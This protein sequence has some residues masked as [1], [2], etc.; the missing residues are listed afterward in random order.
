[1]F[2]CVRSGCFLTDCRAQLTQPDAFK[3][4]VGLVLISLLA[5]QIVLLFVLRTFV[6]HR[7]ASG[8]GAGV[9]AVRGGGA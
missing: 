5:V 9:G 3:L 2:A 7:Q 6:L 8:G 4:I 1:M